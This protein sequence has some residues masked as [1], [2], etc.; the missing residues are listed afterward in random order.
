MRLEKGLHVCAWTRA[1]VKNVQ[2]ASRFLSIR[3]DGMEVS[4]SVSNSLWR[5]LRVEK[6]VPPCKHRIAIYILF[7]N[8]IDNLEVTGISVR[9]LASKSLDS[10]YSKRGSK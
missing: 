9:L 4:L 6:F 2:H 7:V 8:S 1:D 5:S 10:I 3:E